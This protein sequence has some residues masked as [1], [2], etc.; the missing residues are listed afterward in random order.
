MTGGV[1]LHM[2]TLAALSHLDFNQAGAHSYE[3][4]FD[5]MRRLGL[6]ASPDISS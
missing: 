6:P 1:K 4:A 2:Q 5:A 3:Q